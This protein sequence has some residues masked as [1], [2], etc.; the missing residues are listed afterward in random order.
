MANAVSQG[1]MTYEA[2]VHFGRSWKI[3]EHPVVSGIYRCD[4]CF[5]EEE[6]HTSGN[7]MP[8]CRRCGTLTAWKL[9]VTPKHKSRASEILRT[10]EGAGV[11]H[12]DAMQGG[13]PFTLVKF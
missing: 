13:E 4:N 9:I 8:P 12:G 5:D 2:N 3:D 10:I 1:V 6:V 7:K 11:E